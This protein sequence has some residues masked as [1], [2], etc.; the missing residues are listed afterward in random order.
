MP[1]SNNKYNI[2]VFF[3]FE[4]TASPSE[5]PRRPICVELAKRLPPLRQLLKKGNVVQ[6]QN[7][8]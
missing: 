3:T 7:S 6:Q 4:T 5:E 2:D 8:L 1:W